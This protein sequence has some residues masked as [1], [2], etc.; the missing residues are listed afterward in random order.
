MNMGHTF[1]ENL[2]TDS[3]D[4]ALLKNIAND[5]LDKPVMLD[6]L[7]KIL[8]DDSPYIAH[9]ETEKLMSLF[10]LSKEYF[11]TCW[12]IYLDSAMGGIHL[13]KIIQYTENTVYYVFAPDGYRVATVNE[14]N[15]GVEELTPEVTPTLPDDVIEHLNILLWSF[16]GQL[17]YYKKAGLTYTYKDGK[18]EETDYQL[19]CKAGQ[20]LRS[21]IDWIAVK[22]NYERALAT[23]KATK[24]ASKYK[25]PNFA[26]DEI[27][28]EISTKQI[29]YLCRT[30][31]AGRGVTEAQQETKKILFKIQKDNYKP[32]PHE[33]AIMRK[34]YTEVSNGIVEDMTKKLDDGVK[35]LCS[36]ISLASSKSLIEKTH[37]VFKVI[38]T[39]NKTGK[40]SDKQM[41]ILLSAKDE[42]DKKNRLMAEGNKTGKDAEDE[43]DSMKELFDMSE[44]L[45][46][47][48][49]E[50][51]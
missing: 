43:D 44:A 15:N 35:D 3:N 11:N 27:S 6:K 28:C 32:L 37:F 14:I 26:R 12:G 36:Y 25:Y 22:G 18:L 29:I 40:C 1:I 4:I 49:L 24:K 47:G 5:K 41:S 30:N 16:N 38:N 23:L 46:S 50:G 10:R 34:A 2:L 17:R 48:I 13:D 51:Q 45:G 20:K 9:I 8:A 7:L 33:V 21:M 39:I 19:I 31:I 42:I